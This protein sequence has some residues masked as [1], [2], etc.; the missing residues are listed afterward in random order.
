MH[1]MAYEHV[2]TEKVLKGRFRKEKA[3]E[4]IS[5]YSCYPEIMDNVDEVTIHE[6]NEKDGESEWFIT[7]EEAPLTWKEKDS[8]NKEYFELN[9]K[10]VSGD[11]DNI[12]GAWKI[13]NYNN[14]GIRIKFSIDYNLGIPVIEEVLGHILKEKMKNNIDSMIAAVEKLLQE[15]IEERKFERFTVDKHHNLTINDK[16]LRTS[17]IDVSRGGMMIKFDGKIDVINAPV[18]INGTMIESEIILDDV[19]KK[20]YRIVFNDTLTDEDTQKLVSLFSRETS[21]VQE[22]VLLEK[23]YAAASDQDEKDLVKAE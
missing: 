7:I 3:W 21:Q 10:S 16:I 4:I 19:K 17:I 1:K 11:F 23:D 20:N 14:E 18:K 8:F 2:S 9:F 13:E 5:D 6:R 22:A 15:Q 12:D